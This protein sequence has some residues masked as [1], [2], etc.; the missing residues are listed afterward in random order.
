MSHTKL[1]RCFR[2]LTGMTV[3]AFLRRER[4]VRAR[5]MIEDDGFNVT[6]TAYAVGYESISHF[7]QAYKNT[8][9]SSPS[10]CRHGAPANT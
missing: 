3:F 4:L 5:Q 1:N 9:A 8:S 7:S 6:E 10:R 2:Q